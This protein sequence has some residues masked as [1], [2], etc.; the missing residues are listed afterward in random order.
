MGRPCA[1]GLPN[2]EI[3]CICNCKM[4][5][6][7]VLSP[8]LGHVIRIKVFSS[9][10]PEFFLFTMQQT[11]K[12]QRTRQTFVFE[13]LRLLSSSNLHK[14]DFRL[15]KTKICGFTV[16]A[17]DRFSSLKQRQE[18]AWRE[19]SRE[20]LHV[21][22]NSIAYWPLNLSSTDFCLIRTRQTFVFVFQRPSSKIKH[23]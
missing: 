2:T 7:L 8:Y 13:R 21:I 14:T 6:C 12:A 19:V 23:V 9:S 1:M 4:K 16:S 10:R 5:E 15:W 22:K 18:I 20:H 3:V 17:Q 11:T